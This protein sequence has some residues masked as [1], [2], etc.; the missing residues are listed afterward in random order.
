MIEQLVDTWM[1]NN[2][3]NLMVLDNLDKAALECTLS[4]R[5]GRTV[6]NQFAH[7]YAVRRTWLRFQQT[8]LPAVT[9]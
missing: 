9:G 1:I 2:R 6:G 7:L 4:T 5:G 8:V 3:V